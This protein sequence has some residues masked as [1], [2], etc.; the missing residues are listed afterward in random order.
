MLQYADATYLVEKSVPTTRMPWKASIARRLE[1][2]ELLTQSA[3][4]GISRWIN[5]VLYYHV[6][7]LILVEG[8]SDQDFITQALRLL[9]GMEFRVASLATLLG[10]A[11]QG[12][13]QT[14]KRYLASNSEAILARPSSAPLLLILDWDAANKVSEFKGLFGASDPFHVLAWPESNANPKLD[15]TFKGIERFFTDDLIAKAEAKDASLVATKANGMRTINPQDYG[16]LKRILADIVRK[17]L[18]REDVAFAEQFILDLGQR[19]REH[20]V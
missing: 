2:S 12:G 1:A 4:S 15:K 11:T 19:A 6:E 9:T 14:L 16:Q 3:R 13:V 18:H 10:D 5:P 17:G 7:P 8:K 20:A